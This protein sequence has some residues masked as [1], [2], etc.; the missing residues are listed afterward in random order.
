VYATIP[1]DQLT[2]SCPDKGLVQKVLDIDHLEID[3]VALGDPALALTI[4]PRLYEAIREAH[5]FKGPV[6]QGIAEMTDVRGFYGRVAEHLPAP[7]Q[8]RVA[9]PEAW[10]PSLQSLTPPHFG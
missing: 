7:R 4:R 5:A 6:G 9:D 3:L 8:L 10:P 1:I 2:L